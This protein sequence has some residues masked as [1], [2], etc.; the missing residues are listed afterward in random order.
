MAILVTGSTGVIGKQ[1]LE[2]LSSSGA[3]IRGLTRAP[4][5]ATFPNG[6]TAVKGDLADIDS[7]RQAMNGV[8]TLFLLAPNAADELTQALQTLSIAREADV[9][10]WST[11]RSSRERISS[12]CRTSPVNTRSNA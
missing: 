9:K 10:G 1:V 2:H 8:S 12:T 5:R 7:V 11:S 6:V 3:E 4:E